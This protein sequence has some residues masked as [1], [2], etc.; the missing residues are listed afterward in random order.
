MLLGTMAYSQGWESLTLPDSSL[1]AR[2]AVNSSGHVFTNLAGNVFRS[3]NNGDSWTAIGT[4]IDFHSSSTIGISREDH[5]YISGD[6]SNDSGRVYFSRDNGA[7]WTAS[8]D[9]FVLVSEYY[10]FASDTSGNVYA[11]IYGYVYQSSDSGETWSYWDDGFPASSRANDLLFD[12]TNNSLVVA[13]DSYGIY[14]REV[15]DTIW[16]QLGSTELNSICV[17]S[18]IVND[19][20][21]YVAATQAGIYTY[22]RTSKV[23]DYWTKTWPELPDTSWEVVQ[24]VVI[25]QSGDIFAAAGSSIITCD[26][27]SRILTSTNDGDTWSSYTTGVTDSTI[28]DLDIES[29]CNGYMYA[30]TR[31]AT[32]YRSYACDYLCGDANSDSTVNIGDAVFIKAYIFDGGDAPDP[33]EA[34]DA[35]CDGSVNIGDYVYLYQFIFN[36]GSRPCA[37]CD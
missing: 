23:P 37:T 30:V 17:T 28:Q 33:I 14:H 22:Y 7:T 36:Y 16:S 15:T 4:N 19:V 2:V 18:L 11:G 5:I 26:N 13:F 25:N 9:S 3:T 12:E 32:M 35:N 24:Y 31:G 29:T 27:G 10:S 6:D 21:D 8:D 34:G 20:G 1:Y